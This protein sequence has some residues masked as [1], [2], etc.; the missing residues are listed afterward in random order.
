MPATEQNIPHLVAVPRE[1][2]L[3]KEENRIRSLADAAATSDLAVE[4]HRN[5]VLFAEDLIDVHESA[6]ARQA[7]QG[8]D[9][10]AESHRRFAS[11]AWQ[12]KLYHLNQ[13]SA[14]LI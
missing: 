3:R 8:A 6:A 2:Y 1:Q 10:F 4:L 13:L 11:Q 14:I 9:H 7:S 12:L 5:A